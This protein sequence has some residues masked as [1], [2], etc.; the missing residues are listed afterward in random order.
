MDKTN[1]SY[2]KVSAG[3]I[4]TLCMM[5]CVMSC[6]RIDNPIR[7][8]GSGGK[9]TPTVQQVVETVV[10][11]TGANPSDV[12]A[13]LDAIVTNEAVAAAAAKGE[14]IKVTVAG[15]GVSTGAADNKITIPQKNGAN[16]EI[17]FATA[18]AGTGSNALVL[19]TSLGAGTIPGDAN[20]NLTVTMPP[21]SG[22]AVTIELPTTTVTLKTDGS[23]NVVYQDVIAK[24]AKQTIIIDNGVT[25]KEHEL[26][27]G[28]IVVK[29]G[30]AIE[31][32]AVTIKDNDGIIALG[33]WWS[34]V[35]FK[36]DG[37]EPKY[38]ILTE[39]GD[40]YIPKKIK[41]KKGAGNHITTW[42]VVPRDE[43]IESLTAGNGVKVSVLNAPQYRVIKGE[44]N[45][46]LLVQG[47]ID[48]NSD[49]QYFYAFASNT[50]LVKNFTIK[51]EI[52]DNPDLPVHA[53]T[54][55]A[56]LI[57]NYN[58][59]E[60]NGSKT[61]TFEN[62]NFDDNI[63]FAL[64][65]IRIAHYNKYVGFVN[66]GDERPMESR[67]L[68]DLLNAGIPNNIVER[69]QTSGGYWIDD[70]YDD[71]APTVSAYTCI[72]EF[73]NC[74]IGGENITITNNTSTEPPTYQSNLKFTKWG[75]WNRD[76]NGIKFKVIVDGTLYDPDTCWDPGN[77]ERHGT[78]ELRDPNA[79]PPSPPAGD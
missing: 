6:D 47:N 61:F 70:E 37:P 54:D 53:F 41:V 35:A 39:D 42:T 65:A 62:C 75:L 49:D 31:T 17:S 20:N 25:I 71:E 55:P 68:N 24:T 64:S 51:S 22:L 12:T 45:N 34:G 1:Y 15:S 78:I 59:V 63:Q 43:T 77:D 52:D 72:L 19:E 26:V 5:L 8:G 28:N 32:L 30:G 18:P 13:A 7:Y 67:N 74:K 4:F 14:P 38:D 16:I 58:A 76:N 23:G 11:V 46:E 69:G 73:K 79:A 48:H 36:E 9:I 56:N 21:S 66:P 50:D 33:S 29:N 27:G 3:L 44:G 40:F 10:N 2:V 60:N 57:I